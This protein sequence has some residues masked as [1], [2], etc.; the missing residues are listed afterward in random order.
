M[1]K[2]GRP[3]VLVPREAPMHA[4][5]LENLLTLAKLGVKIIP[6]SPGFYH[7]P[8]TIDDLVNMLVGK[9]CDQLGL[10]ANL[11]PRWEG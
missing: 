4:I 6:A 2:E 9:I 5:H 8:Q 3:L 11:F 1:L 10:D 7:R